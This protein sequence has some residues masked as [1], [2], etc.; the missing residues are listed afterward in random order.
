MS[1]Y[2]SMDNGTQCTDK[3]SPAITPHS[4][5]T[6]RENFTSLSLENFSRYDSPAACANPSKLR[7]AKPL[8]S[9]PQRRNS[10]MNSS[11]NGSFSGL[12][13]A[14]LCPLPRVPTTT[15]FQHWQQ[16]HPREAIRDSHTKLHTQLHDPETKSPGVGADSQPVVKPS[17][18]VVH[19]TPL[20]RITPLGR[21]I[22]KGAMTAKA[23]ARLLMKLETEELKLDHQQEAILDAF[24]VDC[25]S[26]IRPDPHAPVIQQLLS[27]TLS[28]YIILLIMML[29]LCHSHFNI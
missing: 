28:C 16:A 13:A 26:H 21:K 6:S 29:F 27:S 2:I 18:E 25:Q 17:P 14:R 19:P 4:H 22:K 10:S 23:A 5:R 9:P 1:G 7:V 12:G 15:A 8:P 11:K 20:P 24:I 3:P